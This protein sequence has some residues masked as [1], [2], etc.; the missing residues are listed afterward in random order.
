MENKWL[1]IKEAVKEG[2]SI[3]R[4]VTLSGEE[5]GNMFFDM[6]APFEESFEGIFEYNSVKYYGEEINSQGSVVILGAGHVSVEMAKVFS[7][8]DY[9]ITVVDDREEFLTKERF[10]FAHKLVFTEFE[11][12]FENNKF[13]PDTSFIIVTRGHKEDGFCLEKVLENGFAYCGM[14]G[15]RKKVA[16]LM[17]EMAKKGFPKALLDDVCSPIGLKIGA[18]TPGEIAVATAAEFILKMSEYSKSPVS[19]DVLE[20][21]GKS[22]SV[23]VTIIDKKGS[24]PRGKGAKMI[25]SKTGE[26]IG[27]IGGGQGEFLAVKKAIEMFEKNEHFSIEKYNMDNKTAASEGMICGG[28]ITVLFEKM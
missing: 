10:P 7:V 24:A 4:Y 3:K 6:E 9:N 15:S 8:L 19:A 21:L 18:V 25:V 20:N 5:K 17:E 11:S 16:I 27:T 2:S 28:E 23:I 14:I 26:T 22:D 12:F 1:Y 13:S